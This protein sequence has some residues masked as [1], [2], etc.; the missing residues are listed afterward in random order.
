M[1]EYLTEIQLVCDSLAGCGHPIEEM[2]Q[3][4]IILNGVKGQYDNV[5]SVIHASRNPYDLA[6]IT[7]VLLDAEAR[8]KEISFDNC[9]PTAHVVVKTSAD[10]PS[11]H[12]TQ[13]NPE[14]GQTQPSNTG[15]QITP[16]Y[17]ANTTG[18]YPI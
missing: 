4:S 15:Q 7:S 14:S 6:S 13:N 16:E 3:I 12:S 9:F 5:V 18:Y 8:Q 11:L 2:Q 10:Q 17:Q 1:R